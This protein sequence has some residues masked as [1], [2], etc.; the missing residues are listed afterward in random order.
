MRYSIASKFASIL[1]TTSS[2]VLLLRVKSDLWFCCVLGKPFEMLKI[3]SY[4]YRKFVLDQVPRS[5]E[6]W[7]CYYNGKS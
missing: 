1:S 3:Y 5:I 4:L 6:H 7:L 2:T